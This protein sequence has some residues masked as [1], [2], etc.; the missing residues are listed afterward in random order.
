VGDGWQL[1]ELVAV[2]HLGVRGLAPYHNSLLGYRNTHLSHFKEANKV[3][4]HTKHHPLGPSLITHIRWIDE[5]IDRPIAIGKISRSVGRITLVNLLLMLI[6]AIGLS[7]CV[8]SR[9][10]PSQGWSGVA[11]HQQ[12][13]YVGTK[14][15]RVLQFD[16]RTGIPGPVFEAEN[17]ETSNLY[18]AFYG[19]PT[20]KDGVLYIGG[21]HGVVY[22]IDTKTMTA[23]SSFEIDGEKLSKGVVGEVA[24]TNGRAIVGSS[25]DADSGRVYVLDATTLSEICR[26]PLEGSEPIGQIWSSPTVVGNTVYIG[27]LS[28]FLHAV[29][30]DDCSSRWIHPVELGGA[31]VAPPLFVDGSLYVGALDRGFYRIDPETGISMKILESKNWF[32][33]GAIADS[34]RLFVPSME[35]LIY[36]LDIETNDVLWSYPFEGDMGTI[37]SRPVV[38]EDEIVIGTDDEKLIVLTTT[39]GAKVWEPRIGDKVRAPLTAEGSI[40]YVHALD[41][42]IRAFDLQTKDI[43]PLWERG[44]GSR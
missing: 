39:D 14:D 24:V 34:K 36:A 21:Y 8:G 17:T 16:A 4:C 11:I 40:V 23:F 3:N 30:I 43:R 41:E 35:G 5:M 32:W 6:L 12:K 18:P 28:H 9:T 20:I 44:T 37:L 7:A 27:D 42:T 2:I 13:A 29:S 10:A 38:V 19:T 33:S 22:A 15:G 1:K 25:E 26:Y 31:I